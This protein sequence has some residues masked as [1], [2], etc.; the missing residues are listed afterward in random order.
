[1]NKGDRYRYLKGMYSALTAGMSDQTYIFC[2]HRHNIFGL[3]RPVTGHI[4]LCVIDDMIKDDELHLL[5][6]VPKAWVRSDYQTRFENIATEFGPV[7]LK[8]KLTEDGKALDVIYEPQF[9]HQPKKVALHVPPLDGLK[10]VVINGKATKTAA[11][12]V[13]MVR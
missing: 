10:K 12:D 3:V 5:R 11:G 6:L 8:F 13:I 1:L 4:K 9:R 2:E 7:T